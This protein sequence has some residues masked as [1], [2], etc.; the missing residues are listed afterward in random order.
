[1][2]TSGGDWKQLFLAAC[3]GDVDLVRVYADAGVDLDYAHPEFCTT[4]LVACILAGQ[5]EAAH[6]L[7]DR[8]AD[9]ELPS[10]FDQATPLEAAHIAGITS[11]IV[12]LGGTPPPAVTADGK[13]PWWSRL[14]ARQ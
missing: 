11:L 1:M 14:L 5:E 6:L 13:R 4:P 2:G 7:L 10:E 9:P 3:A 12:R 8:G